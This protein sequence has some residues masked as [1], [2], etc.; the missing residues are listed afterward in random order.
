[1]LSLWLVSQVAGGYARPELLVDT[2]WVAAHASDADVRL[3]DLRPQGYA[4]GHIPHAVWLDNNWIRNPK[5]PP[6]FLPTP[7]EFTALMGRL[8]FGRRRASSPTTT[9]AASMR[10]AC[11]GS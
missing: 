5:A 3:V 11:G 10:R 7:A 9:A 1:M 6:D 8:G 2:E 4:D